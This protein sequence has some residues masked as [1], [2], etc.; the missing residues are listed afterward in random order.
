[1]WNAEVGM[2]WN[3][4]C[5][6]RNAELMYSVDFKISVAAGLKSDQSD[7]RRN[8]VISNKG[9]LSRSDLILFVLVLVLVLGD[10]NFIED[11][12]STFDFAK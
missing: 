7:R 3:A 6:M 11:E 1:M 4:E 12:W 2:F 9:A 8:F 5:G 10:Q